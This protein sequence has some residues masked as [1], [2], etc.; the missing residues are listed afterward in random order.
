MSDTDEELVNSN[1]EE[2]VKDAFEKAKAAAALVVKS[3]VAFNSS[4]K[5]LA[6]RCAQLINEVFSYADLE[7]MRIEIETGQKPTISDRAAAMLRQID[8]PKPV[9]N[10]R[11]PFIGIWNHFYL[12]A[13]VSATIQPLRDG[14]NG[15][16]FRDEEPNRTYTD[17]SGKRVSI[18]GYALHQ[19]E[20]NQEIQ[21][22]YDPDENTQ[23]KA[24]QTD[25]AKIV[26]TH[27]FGRYILA[28]VDMADDKVFE[29]SH[30]TMEK[31]YEK[32]LKDGGR[33]IAIPTPKKDESTTITGRATTTRT[34]ASKPAN[35]P[36]LSSPASQAVEDTASNLAAK[37]GKKATPPVIEDGVVETDVE[38]DDADVE[39]DETEEGVSDT[40]LF[41]P[42]TE[43]PVTTTTT[44]TITDTT[45]AVTTPEAW[46]L[47]STPALL[48]E[49][50]VEAAEVT[51]TVAEVAEVA[52]TVETV[53]ETVAE[54]ADADKIV[55]LPVV[56]YI[57]LPPA[58]RIMRD[59]VIFTAA[60]A[61]V[62]EV[63]KAAFLKDNER[64]QL[65]EVEDTMHEMRDHIEI[66]LKEIAELTAEKE[67]AT[68]PRTTRRK[69]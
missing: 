55:Q 63:K 60:T 7:L 54:V 16:V 21:A 51:E 31:T 42:P 6:Y 24:E 17:A 46:A 20:A 11:N 37:F 29:M 4:R 35:V 59:D 32:W 40:G 61:K 30:R 8:L 45:P 50:V 66:L 26:M 36:A 64:Q 56:N 62:R 23:H 34:P 15:I 2:L 14:K 52:E 5:H 3:E 25:N 38:T 41:V 39:A 44:D 67:A 22:A 43:L 19:E 58:D 9:F 33:S 12:N 57:A 18:S 49:T 48:A 28:A 13:R 68:E 53:A 65:Q 69:P 47:P 27:R 10:T 1:Y